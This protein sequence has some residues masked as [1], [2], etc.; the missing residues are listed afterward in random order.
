M[1]AYFFH[2]IFVDHICKGHTADRIVDTISG[3]LERLLGG[4]WKDR[5]FCAVTDGAS[6]VSAASRYY[7]KPS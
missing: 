6:N 3:A 1:L 4:D 7:M 2:C 5:L